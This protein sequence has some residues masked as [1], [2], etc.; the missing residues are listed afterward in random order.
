[1]VKSKIIADV[2]R[3]SLIILFGIAVSCVLNLASDIIN[4]LFGREGFEGKKQLVFFHMNGCGHCKKMM[5]EWEKL[6]S[7]YSGEVSLKKVEASSGD[8]LLKKNKIS[9]FPTILLLD[10]SGNKLKEYNGDRTAKSLEKF[11]N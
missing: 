4:M 1:M 6:E 10:E 9:G 5:P 11:L 3:V 7:T 8:D 2:K